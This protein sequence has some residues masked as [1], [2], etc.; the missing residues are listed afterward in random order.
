M[1]IIQDQNGVNNLT[2]NSDGSINTIQ[3]FE[4]DDGSQNISQAPLRRNQE[5]S[6]NYRG[7]VGMDSL[8]FDNT[9][10]GG[11]TLNY[12]NYILYNTGFAA[13]ISNG[14]FQ[15]NP[16][17]ILTINAYTNLRT[18]QVFTQKE[19]A[20]LYFE[21]VCSLQAVP[22]NNSFVEI[23][24]GL[25]NPVAV[26][27][28]LTDGVI[29]RVNGAGNIE[30]VVCNKSSESVITATGNMFKGSDIIANQTFH[31]IIVVNEDSAEFWIDD[32]LQC[33]I[34]RGQNANSLTGVE[35][36]FAYA[37]HWQTS[38]QTL[39][40]NFKISKI[41]VSQGDVLIGADLFTLNALAGNNAIQY[42]SNQ[43]NSG[44]TANYTNSTAPTSGT[45][46]NTTPGFS[47]LGG[48]F[49]F[50]APAG[51]ETDYMLFNFNPPTTYSTNNVTMKKLIVNSVDISVFN[52]GAASATT[53]TLLQFS[54]AVFANSQTLANTDAT[55]S[56]NMANR[57]ITLG[58]ISIPVGTPIGG[59]GSN[60]ISVK[61]TSPIVVEPGFM[62]AIVLK[63][64]VG[65][66]T[67]SQI[68]R[69]V[70][71]INGSW[72]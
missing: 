12:S 54:V 67:A 70:C 51:A 18:R 53:P 44:K 56:E 20:P 46:S 16:S 2:V 63:V 49:Q 47:T 34:N 8:L 23:G 31:L 30:Y 52:M 66:A 13:A 64:P 65:T 1:A 42:P 41:A 5:V 29:F 9:F 60:D 72:Y 58:T 28:V 38:A 7:R 45:L 22:Q 37:K 4:S 17:N 10:A 48:Q 6:Y 11:G 43:N 40:Q 55:G 26:T 39:A 19:S 69:G 61:F 35:S 14:F 15:T 68:I 27:N 3:I 25:N 62:F 57:V 71:G 50:A 59:K 32:K 36:W 21:A 33:I 24:F